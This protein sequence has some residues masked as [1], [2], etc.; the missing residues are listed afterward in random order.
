MNTYFL[1]G[2]YSKE[3]IR[4]IATT[5]TNRVVG[6]IEEHNG[7]IV[8]LYTLLGSHDLVMIVNLP[9]NLEAMKASV[10]LAQET[11]I[12]FTSMPALSVN[13][14]DELLDVVREGDFPNVEDL[15]DDD[16]TS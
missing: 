8:H 15:L 13:R 6:I 5:R 7:Q 4:E 12:R 14:F 16:L 1:F 2:K 11:G 9:S 3:S 10:Q